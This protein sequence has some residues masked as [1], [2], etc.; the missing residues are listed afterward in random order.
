MGR[1]LER[2]SSALGALLRARGMQ[3]RL[4][5]Y[6]ILGRWE[7]TVGPAIASHAHPM[8]L[9][10]TKLF[11]AV[12]SPAWMQQLSLLRPEIIEKLNRVLGKDKVKEIVLNLGDVPG[13]VR[14]SDQPEPVRRE[15][16]SEERQ[17]IE[18]FVGEVRDDEVRQAIRRVIEKD[19]LRKQSPRK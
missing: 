4:S 2:M 16:T 9:R 1:K 8:S 13:A 12:D 17:K 3:A 18:G 14:R 7:R 11:L 5:E 19:F 10:G 15:L 6:H